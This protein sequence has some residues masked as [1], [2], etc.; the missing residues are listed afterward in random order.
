MEWFFLRRGKE[1]C[2]MLREE[3]TDEGRNRNKE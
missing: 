2:D 3:I 1:F